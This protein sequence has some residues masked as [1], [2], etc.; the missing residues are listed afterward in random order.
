MRDLVTH[1]ILKN[2]EVI[3]TLDHSVLVDLDIDLFPSFIVAG[4]LCKTTINGVLSVR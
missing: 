1:V 3:L 2:L 4:T